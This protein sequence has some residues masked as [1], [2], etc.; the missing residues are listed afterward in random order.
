M[1]DEGLFSLFFDMALAE[2]RDI[3]W[4]LESQELP[5]EWCQKVLDMDM[6]VYRKYS[7]SKGNAYWY[8]VLRAIINRQDMTKELAMKCCEKAVSVFIEESSRL[9]A[10]VCATMLKKFNEIPEEIMELLDRNKLKTEVS[11]L[12]GEV[13][14]SMKE[15][16]LKDLCRLD[17]DEETC[18]ERMYRL[19]NF[20]GNLNTIPDYC[21]PFLNKYMN[22]ASKFGKDKNPYY[23]VLSSYRYMKEPLDDT[24]VNQA[25]NI[26]DIVTK[27]PEATNVK[28]VACNRSISDYGIMLLL[29]K[30][31]DNV[32]LEEINI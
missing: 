28:K 6:G 8:S 16:T 22:K 26:I 12:I 2:H 10:G 30:I 13:P 23:H 18:K 19:S 15:H 14:D 27:L 25:L 32:F 20:L 9:V 21:M 5:L 24:V 29:T 4:L 1:N 31:N 17:S 3:H 7:T 11:I